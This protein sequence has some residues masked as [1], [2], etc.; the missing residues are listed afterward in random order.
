MN[1]KNYNEEKKTPGAISDLFDL[2]FHWTLKALSFAVVVIDVVL[3]NIV[4]RLIGEI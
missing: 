2:L 1:E 4:G 3:K